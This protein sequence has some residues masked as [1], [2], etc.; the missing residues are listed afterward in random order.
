MT[1]PLSNVFAETPAAI[2][3]LIVVP[4]VTTPILEFPEDVADWYIPFVSSALPKP[5]LAPT[6]V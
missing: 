3:P 2:T 6:G 1:T 4:D 5:A